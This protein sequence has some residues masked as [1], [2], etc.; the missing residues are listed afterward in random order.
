MA[1]LT[2]IREKADSK[3]TEFWAALTAK[4]EAYY[5]KHNKY[6]QLLATQEVVDGVDT[7]FQKRAPLDERNVED[8]DIT[9][10]S[11]IPFQLWVDEWKGSK[12]EAGYVATITVKLLD[13][14]IFT[15]S[16]NNLNEDSGWNEYVK[17]TN[18]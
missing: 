4:Q 16:R 8:A 12:Q 10:E 14:R 7:S 18:I 13:G 17:Q 6:F 11:P 1:T 15:R 9:F 3:L 2:Q 5:A